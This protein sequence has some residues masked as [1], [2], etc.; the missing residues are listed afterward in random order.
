MP[1]TPD[2]TE[3]DWPL[4]S[5]RHAVS[6]SVEAGMFE[7]WCRL[8]A[9]HLSKPRSNMD[10]LVDEACGRDDKAMREYVQ[11]VRDYIW[12]PW[13]AKMMAEA[14]EGARDA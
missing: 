12:Q 10:R 14:A 11:F 5:L 2:D 1:E 13:L 8:F 7:E 4:E 3:D 6:Q 9:P